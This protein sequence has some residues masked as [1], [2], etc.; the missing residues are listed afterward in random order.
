MGDLSLKS[1][2]NM[3]NSTSESHNVAQDGPKLNPPAQAGARSH[4]S[5]SS[6]SLSR[7]QKGQRMGSR[8]S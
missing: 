5:P 1:P 8:A 4:E 2:E 6:S 3:L 7:N